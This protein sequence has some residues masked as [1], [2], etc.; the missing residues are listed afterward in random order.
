[1][2]LPERRRHAYIGHGDAAFQ[3]RRPPGAISGMRS[4]Y[5]LVIDSYFVMPP[6]VY[7]LFEPIDC[8]TE[9]IGWFAPP[10]SGS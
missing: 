5:L 9:P 6:Q 1:M 8:H 10:F 7:Y 4:C 2:M 3:I